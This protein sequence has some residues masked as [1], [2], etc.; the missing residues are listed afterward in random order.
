MKAKSL[1]IASIA[2]PI[3]ALIAN[4]VGHEW[5]R[6]QGQEVSIPI[7]GFDPRDLLSGH[8]LTYQLQYGADNSNCRPEGAS[9]V[10]CLQPSPQLHINT[11]AKPRNCDLYIRG[12]CG[13]L[14]RFTANI[15]RFYIPE[16]YATVLDRK[17][18]DNQG[19]LVLGVDNQGIATIRDL[20][21]D[22]KPWKQ[23]VR[24]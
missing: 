22:G 8:F 9:A 24:D 18:R 4:A 12:Q 3:I 19:A 16:E 23:A 11:Q 21:I 17:V 2:L 7:T 13:G 20:L 14:G 5:A 10:M 1:L 6:H 15:E